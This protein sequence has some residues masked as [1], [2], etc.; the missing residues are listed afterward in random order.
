M[1][2]LF[3]THKSMQVIVHHAQSRFEGDV[4]VE[5]KKENNVNVLL[6]LHWLLWN[7]FARYTTQILLL[8]KP[9][10]LQHFSQFCNLR[11]LPKTKIRLKQQQSTFFNL[12]FLISFC[13]SWSDVRDL[14]ECSYRVESINVRN[15]AVQDILWMELLL[16]WNRTRLHI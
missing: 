16:V 5:L 7:N 11:N 9:V 13:L 3:I 2:Y 10:Y 8:E 14:V 4:F 1:I 12:F 15:C 6:H